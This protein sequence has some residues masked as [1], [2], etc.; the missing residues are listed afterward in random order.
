MTPS[1]YAG[2]IAAD[3]QLVLELDLMSARPLPSPKAHTA[4]V[5]GV[6]GSH[7]QLETANVA[8]WRDA[9]PTERLKA[10]L[11][12]AQQVYALGARDGRPAGLDRAA[13]GVRRR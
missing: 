10:S 5:G 7:E 8:F 11:V 2:K 13:F 12:L 3:G 4:W 1:W 6:V 9:G